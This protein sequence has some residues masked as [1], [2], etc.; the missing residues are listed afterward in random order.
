V[1][2]APQRSA[3]DHTHSHLTFDLV[4]VELPPGTSAP[5]NAADRHIRRFLYREA[6][7]VE[8]G[9]PIVDARRFGRELVVLTSSAL[10]I[11]TVQRGSIGRWRRRSIVGRA[12]EIAGTRVI[13]GSENGIVLLNSSLRQ[14]WSSATAATGLAFFRNTLWTT[15]ADEVIEWEW[16]KQVFR[17]KTRRSLPGVTKLMSSDLGAFAMVR[18]W[19]WKLSGTGLRTSGRFGLGVVRMGQQL[20][21][22]TEDGAYTFDAGGNVL[23]VY[24]GPQ[25]IGT[26]IGFENLAVEVR[27]A[28]GRL[29]LH[30]RWEATLEE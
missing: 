21:V 1:V 17:G 5:R 20:A 25:R 26:S 14:V 13:V 22:L 11:G 19:I 29:V 3:G 23:A 6:G 24:N 10:L 8:V 15:S 28:T 7:I 27:H 16:S 9:E 18:G 2:E 12:V 30:D 4:P